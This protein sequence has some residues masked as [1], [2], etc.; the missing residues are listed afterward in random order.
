MAETWRER[1]RRISERLTKFEEDHDSFRR[2]HQHVVEHRQFYMAVPVIL[3]VGYVG[4][5]YQQRP[6]NIDVR[7]VIHNSP[8]FSHGMEVLGEGDDIWISDALAQELKD[9][10]RSVI[11]LPQSNMMVGMVDLKHLNDLPSS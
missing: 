5:K 3:G 8:V 4:G 11:H 1:G 2:L 9:L 10:G 6:I 7:P